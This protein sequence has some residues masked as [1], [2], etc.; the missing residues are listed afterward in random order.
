MKKFLKPQPTKLNFLNTEVP[1]AEKKKCTLLTPTSCPRSGRK[2]KTRKRKLCVKY[3]ET[4][5][6]SQ[7]CPQEELDF[8]N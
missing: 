5:L 4:L 6:T 3:P 7:A 1:A 2:K 8:H